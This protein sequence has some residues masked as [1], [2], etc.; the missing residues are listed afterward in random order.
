MGFTFEEFPDA[1][2]YRS[3]L[4]QVLRYVREIVEKINGYDEIIAQLEQALAGIGEMDRRITALENATADLGQIRAS[5]R[6]IQT[7]IESINSQHSA[8][9]SR[10]QR[11]ID[12]VRASI[13]DFD[14][15]IEAARA[16]SLYLYTIAKSEWKQD[17]ATITFDVNRRIIELQNDVKLLYSLIESIDTSLTNPWHTELG[18]IGPSKNNGLVYADLADE[19]LTANQY[20]ALG[21][22]ASEYSAFN[23]SAIDYARFGK[24]LLHYH[25]VYSPAFGFKQ[26]ISN[27]LT[28]IMNAILDTLTANEYTALDIDAEDYTL[29]DLTAYQYYSYMADEG[30]LR[31]DRE[32]ITASQYST[33][34]V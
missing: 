1:D 26:E 27:V 8:D 7:E 28:S 3:D 23:I 18:R 11:E 33:L 2:Y 30:F 34:G 24:T 32:G 10:L 17:I 12:E 15:Q 29:L 9:I 22:T 5:I 21:F 14:D 6:T 25:W 4:R 31:L 19:C 16:Y 20:L 13:R